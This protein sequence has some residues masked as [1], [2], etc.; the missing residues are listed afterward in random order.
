MAGESLIP[1]RDP[2]ENKQYR[3]PTDS[4]HLFYGVAAVPED[5]YSLAITVAASLFPYQHP[6][7]ASS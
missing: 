2:H 7:I 4:Y 1:P 3:S 5:R 6:A